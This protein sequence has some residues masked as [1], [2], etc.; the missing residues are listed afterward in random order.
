MQ[1]GDEIEKEANV[2]GNSRNM[3]SK[4]QDNL[5]VEWHEINW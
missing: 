5:M 1:R 3:M 2:L 4:T